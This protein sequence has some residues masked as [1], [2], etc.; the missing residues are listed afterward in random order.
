M[1]DSYEG[2]P[3][4]EHNR[5]SWNEE[6]RAQGPWSQPVQPEVVA[7]A[8]AQDWAIRLAGDTPVPRTWFPEPLAGVRTLLLAG[9]GGQQ[10]A[11]L[12]AAGAKVTV[13]DNSDE[14]LARDRLVARREGLDVATERGQ[15]DDLSRFEASAFDL[16]V[17]P[18]SNCFVPDVK[19]VYRE[20]FRV[21]RPG[22]WLLAG[23]FNPVFYMLDREADAAGQVVIRYS[24]PYSDLTSLA[25][26]ERLRLVGAGVKVP[27][28][29]F[30]HSLQ[31]Q[32]GGQLEAGFQLTGFLD[33]RWTGATSLDR[34]GAVYILTCAVRP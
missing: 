12:A 3:V 17:H 6:A 13:L 27:H 30:G 10:S 1:A 16:I 2:A 29:E 25:E 32:V 21:L 19:P 11:V 33:S 8:R 31:D 18:C 34:Y 9:G 23:F 7:R 22:G 15:M 26:D 14:Q 4:P 5:L 20:C 28:L 24:V